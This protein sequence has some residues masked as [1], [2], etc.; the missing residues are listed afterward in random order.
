MDISNH[1]FIFL[2]VDVNPKPSSDV[3]LH[4]TI[5]RYIKGDW[6]FF[7]SYISEASLS[8]LFKSE[9]SRTVLFI[10]EC[11]ISRIECFIPHKKCQQKTNSRPWFIPEYAVANAHRSHFDYQ[12]KR[13]SRMLAS[14]RIALNHCKKVVK[15]VKS[16][17]M[18]AVKNKRRK[19][20]LKIPSKNLQRR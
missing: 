7:R 8:P 3:P 19:Q 2:K 9:F 10:S 11:N 4:K 13:Y 18:Q 16:S 17:D 15:N 6:D 14:F 1:C 20:L 5:Y 12:R